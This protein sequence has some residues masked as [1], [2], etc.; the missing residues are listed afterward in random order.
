[1]HEGTRSPKFAAARCNEIAA[2]EEL[3][4]WVPWVTPV[5]DECPGWMRTGFR[6]WDA[7]RV[8]GHAPMEVYPAGCFWLLNDRRWPP[9]KTTPAGRAAR[10]ALLEP[11]VG[12][13]ALTSHDHVDAVMAAVVAR[14]PHRALAHTDAGCDGSSLFVLA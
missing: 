4:I 11:F 13:L 5:L 14:G 6:L 12:T 8:A 1:M 9:R 7:L 3:G 10:L 2:G